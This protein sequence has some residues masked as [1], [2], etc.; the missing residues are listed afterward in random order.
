MHAHHLICFG[1]A[2]G[3]G[4]PALVIEGDGSDASARQ[5]FAQA[6]NTTCVFI[7]EDGPLAATRVDYH[8]PHMRSPLCLHATLAVAAVLFARPGQAQDAELTVQTA[9]KGQR[10]RLTR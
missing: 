5:A 6:R 10:L 3:N 4:N 8:Y 1:A 2:P 9:M 7:D